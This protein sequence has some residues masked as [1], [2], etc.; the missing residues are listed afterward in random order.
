M[1]DTS[2]QTYIGAIDMGTTSSRF[3]IF[4]TTGTPVA[5]HQ[6]EFKQMYPHSGY[7]KMMAPSFSE[8][9]RV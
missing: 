3:I 1:A 7:A 6:I 5:S 9:Q 2:Q 8:L 4:D